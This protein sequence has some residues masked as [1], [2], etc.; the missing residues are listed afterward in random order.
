MEKQTNEVPPN[1]L[2]LEDVKV[3]MQKR[4]LRIYAVRAGHRIYNVGLD[5]EAKIGSDSLDVRNT[6]PESSP[7]YGYPWSFSFSAYNLV[8][9][10][11]HPS[12]CYMFK[13]YWYAQAYLGFTKA[14]PRIHDK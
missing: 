14:N 5:A 4:P 8:P 2:T 12:N 9:D 13:D 6:D 1:V 7:F 10:Q 11:A 3:L